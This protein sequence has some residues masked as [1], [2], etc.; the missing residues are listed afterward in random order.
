M[1]P[2]ERVQR[3]FAH[4][5]PD[6]TPCDYSA[7]HEI[8]DALFERLGASDEDELRERLGTDVRYVNPPYIGPDLGQDASTLELNIWGIET[9]P[10]PNEYGEYAEPVGLP[11]ANFETVR[12]A[13]KF[14]WPSPDWFDYDAVPSL[15][16]KHGDFAIGTGGFFVQDFINSIAF[17][18]GV[19]Q[20]LLDIASEDPV[21]LYMMDRRQKFYMETVER[22][23]QSANG[24]ID[25]VL[26]GDDF[27]S[28]RGLLISP[29]TFEKVFAARKKEFFDMA[30][31]YGARISHHCCGSS[32]D[33]LPALIDIGMD[34]LQTVQPRAAGMNPYDLKAEFG[35]RLVLHGG[36][37]V[38]GWLQQ[39]TP[40]EVDAEINRL[41]D[42][43]GRGGGFILAPCHHIQ[44]DT[45]VEN[46][47]AMYQAVAARRKAT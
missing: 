6:F 34:A 23:L 19:E 44:P 26:C 25:F 22:T 29:A 32:R 37:D 27:G 8:R 9:R 5:Q 13:E 41:M 15:C 3:A 7:T 18:R 43:V 16:E 24:R 1:T 40:G 42:E 28:Q 38:Q 11:Y 4:E 39:A 36:V 35:D 12:D 14:N 17:G 47:I 45:P 33:L 30:H 2:R 10:M 31:S 20:T 21:F 46:A